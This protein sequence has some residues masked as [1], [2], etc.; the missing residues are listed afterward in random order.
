MK[1]G[2]DIDGVILDLGSKVCE[3]FNSLYDTTYTKNDVKQWEFFRDWEVPESII[4]EIFEKAYQ[5]SSTIALIDDDAPHVLEK[6]Y[7]L[8]DL[9][10]ETARN[11]KFESHLVDRLDFLKIRKGVQYGN[12]IHVEPKPYDAKVELN[13]EILIDDNPNLMNSFIILPE[14]RLLLFE[15]PWNKN[16]EEKD[17]IKR[18][19]NWKQIERLLI[20]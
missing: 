5:Q 19:Y 1:I 16:L 17:N 7:K 8:H 4:Y 2:V 9:D 10:L 15:Q 12:L 6:L 11:K 3:I 20:N 13:Y 14:K 18:V